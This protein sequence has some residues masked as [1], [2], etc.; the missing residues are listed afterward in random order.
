MNTDMSRCFYVDAEMGSDGNEGVSSEAAWK[1]LARV[2]AEPLK[3]GDRVR[4]RRGCRWDEMLRP[5]G[6]GCFG[7]P[8][9]L[10]GYGE[11][12]KPWVAGDGGYASLFLDGVSFYTADGLKITNHGKER[13]IRSGICVRAKA[14]GVTE[15][16]SILNCEVTDVNGENRRAMGVYKSMYWNSGIYVTFPGRTSEKDHLH[17]IL[18]QG[19]YVHDVHTSGVRVN[20]QEDFINDIHHTHVVV[21]GNRIERTGSDGII[22]ANCISPLIDGNRCFDA[23]ALGNLKDTQL[24]A[25]VWVCATENALIQR[26]EVARTALFEADGSAF[27]TDWGTAGDTVFQ[28]NYTHGNKGGFWLDCIGL[29]HNE[30][31][32]KTILRYNISIGDEKAI[33]REDK[34]LP[35]EIYGNYFGGLEQMPEVCTR[36]SGCS[37]SFFSNIFD[38]EKEPESGFK[39]SFYRGNWYGSMENLPEDSEGK[40]GV[41]FAVEAPEEG[42]AP[43]G[44][45]WCWKYWERLAA[46]VTKEKKK[47]RS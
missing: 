28:Y 45:D 46:L 12:E 32:G 40:P 4:L 37:H 8:I 10:E 14:R 24:I 23:G 30:E 11:G 29:N 33:T 16:I 25:G 5:Q 6:D 26:N 27:D 31:C 41:P 44:L 22:V 39:A 9:I 15:G 43:E 34:G 19:N 2:N 17:D 47:D 18:I 42:S 20:Q 7:A 38:Y 3:P 1:T 13:G 36:D 35:A 21:R